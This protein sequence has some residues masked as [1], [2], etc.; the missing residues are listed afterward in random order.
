[1]AKNLKIYLNYFYDQHLKNTKKK[2]LTINILYVKV[3]K[4]K[5]QLQN[6]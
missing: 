2:H 5:Q 6:M 3:F 1:M 4:K